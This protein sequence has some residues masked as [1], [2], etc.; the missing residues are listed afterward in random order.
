MYGTDFF[1]N[2]IVDSILR[3]LLQMCQREGNAET[4]ISVRVFVFF[5]YKIYGGKNNPHMGL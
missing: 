5:L 3:S 1:Y 4:A 2:I